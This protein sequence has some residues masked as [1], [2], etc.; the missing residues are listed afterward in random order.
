MRVWNKGEYRAGEEFEV[1]SFRIRHV[2]HGGKVFRADRVLYTEG[3]PEHNHYAISRD[4][5]SVDSRLTRDAAI[6]FCEARI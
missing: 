4:G 3:S 2:M 1:G 6:K 5:A